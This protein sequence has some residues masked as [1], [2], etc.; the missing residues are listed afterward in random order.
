MDH[1]RRADANWRQGA[2]A[3][4]TFALISAALW[5][6]NSYAADSNF[7]AEFGKRWAATRKMAVGVAEAM[8]P[9]QDAFRPDPGS[10]TFGEQIDHIAQINYAFC[11]G[12]NFPS[13]SAARRWTAWPPCSFCRAGWRIANQPAEAAART[14]QLKASV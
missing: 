2:S 8:P 7:A 12:L 4:K 11:A 9:V 5:T 3:M 13:K 1:W 6:A 14:L 10:M